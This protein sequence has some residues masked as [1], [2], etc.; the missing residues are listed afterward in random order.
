MLIQKLKL[1]L[2]SGKKLLTLT[3]NDFNVLDDYLKITRPVASALDRL[4]GDKW[5]SQGYILPTLVSLRIHISSQ[6]GRSSL[7]AFRDV[8]L[9]ALNKRFE[10]YLKINDDNRALIL[11]AMSTPRF[12]L[13]NIV[14]TENNRCDAEACKSF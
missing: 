7:V 11:S 2:N 3:A 14:D 5:C 6:T 4:Q 12:E 1:E 8:M 10:V 13:D 9:K